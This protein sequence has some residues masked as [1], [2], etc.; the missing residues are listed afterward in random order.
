MNSNR[1]YKSNV[2][3]LRRTN[4]QPSINNLT[5]LSNFIDNK[6]DKLYEKIISER[7]IIMPVTPCLKKDTGS[8]IYVDVG[9]PNS[10]FGLNGDVYIDSI[11]LN[12]YSKIHG[13]W[14]YKANI[15]GDKGDTGNCGNKGDKGDKGNKGDKGDKGDQGDQGQVGEQ[16]VKGDNNIIFSFEVTSPGPYSVIVPQGTVSAILTLAGGGGAGGPGGNNAYSGSGGGGGAGGCIYMFPISVSVGQEITGIIG[17]GGIANSTG[18][19]NGTNSTTTIGDSTFTAFGGNG[20][21][22]GFNGAQNE[23]DGG[24][25]GSVST[26]VTAGSF[27][28]LPGAGGH[29][30]GSDPNFNNGGNGNLGNNTYSGAGGGC[31]AFWFNISSVYFAPGKGGNVLGFT[32]GL[33]GPPDPDDPDNPT[34]VIVGGGGGGASALANGGNGGNYV[35]DAASEPGRLGS[36]GG[37][38]AYNI[39]SNGGDGYVNITFYSS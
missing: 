11:T 2:P 19:S 6:L 31:G 13:S 33:A 23:G 21:I 35:R 3:T 7:H 18:A 28:P 29:R 20:G 39:G 4:S 37:G 25:G 5:N 27:F 14:I 17:A 32:G 10:Y 34:L 16:G 36:G 12:L 24:N 9:V 30:G 15:K 8:K 1:K 38:G 26:P 22:I